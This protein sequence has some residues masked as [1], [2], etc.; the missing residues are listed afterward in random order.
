MLKQLK[1]RSE[2]N[3]VFKIC[4]KICHSSWFSKFITLSIIL[5][6]IILALDKYPIED[7]YLYGLDIINTLFFSVFLAEMII[8]MLGLGFK[9]YF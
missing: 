4:F 5:N 3:F 2:K 1:E 9:F 6:T 8:K 7:D